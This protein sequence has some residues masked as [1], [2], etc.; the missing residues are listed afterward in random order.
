V[1]ITIKERAAAAV[2][3]PATDKLTL[4]VDSADGMPKF[5]ND[6]GTLVDLTGPEGPAG[7]QGDPGDM[8]NPMTTA[9]DIITGG[10]SGAPQRLAVGSNDQVLT[11]VAGAPAWAAAPSGGSSAGAA[12][13]VQTSDGS[14][15]FVDS[16]ATIASDNLTISDGASTMEVDV[17]AGFR[18]TDANA[19]V[20]SY[21]VGA[22]GAASITTSG[23]AGTVRAD[24]Y[25]L[26]HNN[27]DGNGSGLDADLLRGTTPSTAGLAL[28]DDAD[29]A[30]QRTTMSAEKLMALRT[31]SD[32]SDDLE[33]AW[34]REFVRFTNAGDKVLNVRTNAT[35]AVPVGY[36]IGIRVS[37]ATANLTIAPAG[38]VTITAPSGGTLVLAPGMSALLVNVGTDAWELSG[39]TVAA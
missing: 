39:Q 3:T 20:A 21:N 34:D 37:A 11:V 28:L 25:T 36:M 30:A 32:A 1:A 19:N 38:G 23:G 35:H 31:I 33:S 5:K 17:S 27:N 6:A 16:G 15:G 26:W 18:A 9:G 24:G 7:P 10:A 2:P 14:G 8:T 13:A 4:F 12:N 22:L 29:A